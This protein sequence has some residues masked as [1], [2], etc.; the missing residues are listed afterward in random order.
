M[1]ISEFFKAY[2]KVARLEY[3]PAEAPGVLIPLLLAATSLRDLIGMH[4]IE[5]VVVFIL[6]FFSGFLINALADIE[7]DS[8]YKTFVSDSV[9]YLGS[10][11]IGY[12]IFFQV[13]IAV[14]LTIH[15]CYLLDSYWLLLWVISG[16]FFGLAYSVRPFHFKVRGVFHATLAFGA[17]LAPMV[18]LYYLIG[19]IPTTSALLVI[20]FFV[21]LHYG[22]VLV[23]QTQD[24]LEDKTSGL[25]TPAVRIG[26]TQTLIISLIISLIGLALGFIG[27]YILFS[28]LSSLNILGYKL[29]FE[30]LYTITVITLVISYYIPLRGIMDLIMISYGRESIEQK[31]IMIKNRLNYPR[32]QASGLFGIMIISLIIFA[33][34]IS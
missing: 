6:L 28:D 26:V 21:I 7:V 11:T 22:I 16:I 3:V 4:V 14:L 32:W 34:K 25:L 30:G 5:G 18:F 2:A 29:S 33:I 9:E 27:F 8:K 10:K 24:Y 13:I 12:L 15:I 23:N 20:L 31:M 19:G 1:S 17:G